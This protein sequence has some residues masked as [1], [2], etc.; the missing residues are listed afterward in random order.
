MATQNPDILTGN[1]VNESAIKLED[2]RSKDDRLLSQLKGEPIDENDK[3]TPDEI[4]FGAFREVMLAAAEETEGGP[5]ESLSYVPSGL[6]LKSARKFQEEKSGE[7]A[8]DEV[9]D[10]IKNRSNTRRFRLESAA[11]EKTNPEL[12]FKLLLAAV[13]SKYGSKEDIA[14]LAADTVNQYM[15]NQSPRGNQ[16]VTSI[17]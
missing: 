4:A 17:S 11:V 1:E 2:W 13:I 8:S 12:A 5:I 10:A 9:W 6:V 15:A 7:K 16:S 3:R 14:G